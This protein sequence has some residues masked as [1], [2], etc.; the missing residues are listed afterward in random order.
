MFFKR[1]S[2]ASRQNSYVD[3]DEYD[4]DSRPRSQDKYARDKYEP[5]HSPPRQ[6]T[7]QHNVHPASPTKETT[8]D[9]YPRPSHAP[10]DV[11]AQ[12][13]MQPIN[14]PSSRVNS[15]AFEAPPP[16]AGKLEQTPDLLARA[17]QESIRPYTDKIE[18]LEAQLVDL[19]SWVDQLELQ[20]TDIYAWIDK[21]GL[22]PGM[23]WFFFYITV[24][25]VLTKS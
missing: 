9:M 14:G 10:H 21:R 8:R 3:D 1:L 24:D 23:P 17:F 15:A 18:Q 13:G 6:S 25:V 4:Y 12:R 20:R 7:L 5:E 16:S 11:Y 19:Q 2:R 22:R